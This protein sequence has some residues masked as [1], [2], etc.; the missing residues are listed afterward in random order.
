M[1]ASAGWPAGLPAGKNLEVVFGGF[2]SAGRKPRNEDAFAAHQPA[3]VARQLKGVTLCIADGA[4]CSDNAQLASQTSVEHFIN[5]YYS[6]PDTWP[7]KTAAARV[8]S[9]LNAW[10][11]HH[12][13][14]RRRAADA[15]VTTF[16]AAVLKST[17]AHLF[18]AGDSRIY[19]WRGEVLEQLTRDH[20]QVQRDG[21]EFLTRA[22]GMDGHLEVD[23]LTEELEVG[24]VLLFTT[25]GT[26][27]WI[28]TAELAA[29]LKAPGLDLE[30]RARSIVEAALQ[31]GSDD[32]ASCLLAE[33]RTL[34][35][36]DIDEI[37][38]QL[39]RLALPPV[40]APGQLIDF[41]RVE[42]VLHSGTRSHVY[43]VRDE[44]DGERRVLKAPSENFADDAQY[45]EGFAREQWVGS[46][47]DHPAVMKILPRPAS[48]PFLYHICEYI[49]GQ[50]LRQWR[51]DHP[52]PSL[53]Q[54]RSFA[55][56]IAVALRALQRLQM[57]HRDLKPENILIAADGRLK[58]I[59]F[60]TVRVPGLEELASSLREAH[61]VGS[62]DYIAPEYL[63]GE[64]GS[65]AS[66]IFSLGVIV[67]ELLTGELP[68][69]LP[70]LSRRG[71]RHWQE[72][73]YIP[74][75]AHRA[76]LPLWVDLALRKAVEPNP[77]QRYQ[78]LSEFLQDLTA[79]NAAMVAKHQAAPLLERNPLRFWQG[80]SLVLF[81]IVLVQWF[82][83]AGG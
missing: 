5:D 60:G 34:P 55:R 62:L 69:K 35:L 27:G 57:V 8:L 37:H 43:Q 51:F 16:S 9:A 78:A 73:Q 76:D 68:F 67:Y 72:W 53:E 17:T 33:V 29:L 23:Y 61:P 56:D 66:D 40:L 71:A 15:L 36:A 11:H 41:F 39:T 52:Q 82:F 21:A 10:L 54:V 12:G 83:L 42:R 4:S 74:A 79:P 65:H 81:V 48:S 50:T 20:R 75:R 31:R 59:D 63:F 25:D 32:N 44:R 77:R 19:R 49:D 14:Q 80:L 30:A 1:D 24:D 58:L 13:Q 26:H 47:I 38:R 64:A 22:L 45:L 2:S 18:H 6:T 28:G 46:R 70:D 7:T 3:V